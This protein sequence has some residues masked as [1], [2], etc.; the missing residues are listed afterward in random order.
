MNIVQLTDTDRATLRD[1]TK[2]GKNAVRV[3][4]R[5]R[6]LLLLDQGKE[7]GEI[8]EAVGCAGRTV[9]N[10][11]HRFCA[12]K[13]IDDALYDKPRPG[14]PKK[15]LPAHEAFVVATACSKAPEGHSH[16]TLAALKT[17]LLSA[18]KKL[19]SI[20]DER[21]RQILIHHDLKPWREK[22]VVHPQSHARLS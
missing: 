1:I 16:W 18:Y 6:I 19:S 10:V 13:K 20:S 7:D 17:A 2:K 15:I 11:L 8:K 12:T 4:L 9:Q 22:N 14:Q 3:V 5:A 21:I